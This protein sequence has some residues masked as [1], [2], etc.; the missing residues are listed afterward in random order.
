MAAPY[1]LE[2]E[3]LYTFNVKALLTNISSPLNGEFIA[4]LF[5]TNLLPRLSRCVLPLY[6]RASF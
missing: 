5:I 4:L 3:W 6:F 1:H 2:Y